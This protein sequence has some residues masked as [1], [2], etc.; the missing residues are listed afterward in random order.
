MEKGNSEMTKLLL[1]AGAKA[2]A[3]NDILGKCPI[4]VAIELESKQLLSILL[5]STPGN[6]ANVNTLDQSGRSAL[7]LSCEKGWLT[8]K[9]HNSE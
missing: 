6:K 9:L 8:F 7:H 4:H 2:D 1:T 3:Y 5:E